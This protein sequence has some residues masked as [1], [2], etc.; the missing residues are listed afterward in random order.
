MAVGRR[1]PEPTLPS[2]AALG[3]GPTLC[4]HEEGMKVTPLDAP[5][6]RMCA[7]CWTV[8][9]DLVEDFREGRIDEAGLS[10]G[11][12]DLVSRFAPDRIPST[13]VAAQAVAQSVLDIT[14]TT[15]GSAA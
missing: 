2:P 5:T 13:L 6:E 10:D 8:Y 14:E 9:H 3:S 12:T 11:L 4:G 7:G 1:V 15:T